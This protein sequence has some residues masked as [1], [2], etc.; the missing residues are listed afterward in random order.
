MTTWTELLHLEVGH[1]Y[2]ADGRARG[3]QFE[4]QPDTARALQRA[5]LVARSDGG[6]LQ[7]I[8][9]DHALDLLDEPIG[10]AWRVVATDPAF[11]CGTEDLA[12]RPGQLLW[13]QA[14]EGGDSTTLETVAMLM[15]EPPVAPL[16]TPR[17]RQLPPFALL[18][19]PL[20]RLRAAS[21]PL[22]LRWPLASRSTVWKYCLFGDWPE[23]ALTIVD[24]AGTTEFTAPLPDRMDN[25]TPMLAFRSRGRL[26]LAQ[27]PPQRFQLRSRPEQDGSAEKVL[28][29]RLPTPAA[30]F[31]A[32][33]VID[34][35]PAVISEI[36]VH[37]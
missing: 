7:L 12:Q 3:L 21:A 2:Y 15:R 18:W 19:L 33:E 10:V 16:L 36:H 13:V 37:R 6:S 30:Q 27:R 14:P 24:L 1:G 11:A 26:P 25:G 34:G 8:G 4:P 9:P 28:I 29:R 5:G 22:R 20:A 31:L 35:Q 23:P 17:D 32:R